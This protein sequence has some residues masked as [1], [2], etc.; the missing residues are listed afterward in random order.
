M[1]RKAESDEYKEPRTEE[2]RSKE[3]IQRIKNQRNS[4]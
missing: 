1:G 4:K 2:P 3:E